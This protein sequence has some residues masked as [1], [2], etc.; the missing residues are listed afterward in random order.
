MTIRWYFDFISPFAYLQRARVRELAATHA[1]EYRP[2]LFAG[3]L[4]RL[5]HKGPAE[6]P[7]KRRFTYRHVVWRAAKLGIPLRFPP[8]HPFNPLAALRLCIAAGC[9]DTAIDAIFDHL[10][11]HGLRGD[12]AES[13]KPVAERL[14]LDAATA[15]ADPN[16]KAQLQAN[17]EAAVADH[18]FGVP[19]FAAD[20]EVFWG[21]DATAMFEDWLRDRAAF[22][23]G[24]MTRVDTLP[25]GSVRRS[26]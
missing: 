19:T 12:D 26:G 14:N 6:M 23:S 3:L 4:Q 5:D 2:I 16:V 15:I 22:E 18:V 25:I 21:E 7:D 8:A 1:I 11:R 17:F 9:T 24:E 13:L 20:G 10:W